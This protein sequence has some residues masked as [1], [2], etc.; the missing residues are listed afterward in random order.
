MPPTTFP[1]P[2]LATR[3]Q[4]LH[5]ATTKT[6]HWAMSAGDLCLLL[7]S[8]I[9][10]APD[11]NC[12][13]GPVSF[14][15]LSMGCP[16]PLIIHCRFIVFKTPPH[17]FFFKKAYYRVTIYKNI[18]FDIHVLKIVYFYWMLISRWLEDWHDLFAVKLRTSVTCFFFKS[19][20]RICIDSN[21]ASMHKL[22]QFNYFVKPTGCSFS[23]TLCDTVMPH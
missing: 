23:M 1:L 14:Y 20:S 16:K 9:T 6:K 5:K 22:M 15:F 13:S 21:K 17:A 8:F 18:L 2:C 12:H 3:W 19:L 10:R 7:L 11:L 4:Q